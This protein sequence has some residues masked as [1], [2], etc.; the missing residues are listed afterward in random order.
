M[1]EVP[2]PITIGMLY[3]LIGES[4]YYPNCYLMESIEKNPVRIIVPKDKIQEISSINLERDAASS[5][6]LR[7]S[8]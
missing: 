1:G 3:S 6:A 8:P 7:N 5:W 2:Y 4:L